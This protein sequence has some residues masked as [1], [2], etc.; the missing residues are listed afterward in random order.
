MRATQRRLVVTLIMI[1]PCTACHV[2]GRSRR[3]EQLLGELAP[4]LR[5]GE[6]LA[7]A[8]RAVPALGV[9]HP[10][11]SPNMYEA[12]DSA[13]P[14]VVAVV[15]S[16]GPLI[17][18][19]ASPDATVEAV[20]LVMSPAIA[21]KLRQHVDQ[22]FGTPAQSTCAGQSL[23]QTDLVDVWDLGRRGGVLLTI[24]E[25][26]PEGIA[27]T[28]RLF[29]YAGGWEPARSMSGFGQASCSLKP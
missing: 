18:E 22:L 13:P 3:A 29:I 17:G 8:R 5:L 24:P 25:R 26:R 10:G 1:A 28:S 2:E 14:R 11:D 23:E 16:P 15:V 12:T 19:H 20:E 4:T 6:S 9:R 21:A 7:D 27:P